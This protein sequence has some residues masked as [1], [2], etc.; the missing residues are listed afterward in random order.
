VSRPGRER[1]GWGIVVPVKGGP[2]AKSRLDAGSTLA[3]AFAADTLEAVAGCARVSRLV[4]VTGRDAGHGAGRGD[5]LP[6][7]RPGLVLQE[8]RQSAPGLDAAV[9][10][11]AAHL[12]ALAPEAPG[13]VLL[14]D[15]PALHAEA[16]ALALSAVEGI[17]EAESTV[18][19]VFVPDARGTGT[20]L[21]AARRPHLL[22]AA[23]GEGSAAAH[24]ALGAYPAVLDLPSLRQ[25]V[26][27]AEDLA[28]AMRIGLGA[29]TRATLDLPREA[30]TA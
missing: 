4:V 3:G 11:G 28:L 24:R 27:T 7:I 2:H 6:R 25:D 22:N 23:F 16:L 5:V 17:L 30:R 8:L 1:S 14:G 20:V 15:L 21:L 9:R 18:D 26:D 29:R 19:Q 10:E 12:A 13:A